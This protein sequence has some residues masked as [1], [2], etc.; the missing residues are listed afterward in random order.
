M[1]Y[2]GL[3]SLVSGVYFLKDTDT[4]KGMVTI[5]SAIVILHLC[6]RIQQSTRCFF[7][8]AQG[9]LLFCKDVSRVA[10]KDSIT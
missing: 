8:S 4:R 7:S 1:S 5:V 10:L 6:V 9:F 2:T 3:L